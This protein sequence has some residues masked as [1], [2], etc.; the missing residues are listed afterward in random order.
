MSVLG[1][2]W[3]RP[4]LGEKSLFLG[5]GLFWERKAYFWAQAYF[6]KENPIFGA[7]PY[8]A[9]KKHAEDE[10]KETCRR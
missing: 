4:I 8:V 10:G 7:H 5:V 3:H 2:C 1:A 6:G 9:E